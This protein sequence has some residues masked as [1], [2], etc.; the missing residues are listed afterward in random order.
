MLLGGP[1]GR[2]SHGRRLHKGGHLRLRAFGRCGLAGVALKHFAFRPTLAAE[3]VSA[4]AAAAAT[5]PLFTLGGLGAFHRIC[6]P[7]FRCAGL[8]RL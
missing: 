4:A 6:G 1:C 7:A 8:Q 3:S 2:G 5:F